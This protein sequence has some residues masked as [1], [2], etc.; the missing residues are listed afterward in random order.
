MLK[1]MGQHPA[2]KRYADIHDSKPHPISGDDG[3]QSLPGA[4]RVTH[5]II[6]PGTKGVL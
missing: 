4:Q 6:K 3:V 2:S 5:N 1:N